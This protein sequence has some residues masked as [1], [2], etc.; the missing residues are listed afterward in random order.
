[1]KRKDSSTI[2]PAAKYGPDLPNPRDLDSVLSTWL[3]DATILAQYGFD[4]E[5]GIIGALVRDVQD[6]AEDFLVFISETDAQL[7]SGHSEE[8]F[9][10]RFASWERQ[11]HARKN[12]TNQRLRQYRRVVVPTRD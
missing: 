9:R 1:V 6:A 8:W 4:R 7:R 12:P 11:G 2:I 3:G 5:A 10:V